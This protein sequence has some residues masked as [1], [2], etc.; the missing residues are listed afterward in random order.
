MIEE[1]KMNRVKTKRKTVK[2]DAKRYSFSFEKSLINAFIEKAGE[3]GYNT[4][5]ALEVLMQKAI[6][7][8]LPKKTVWDISGQTVLRATVGNPFTS[9]KEVKEA[10]E[11]ATT[12]RIDSKSHIKEST[13][14]EKEL[15]QLDPTSKFLMKEMQRKTHNAF[16]LLQN[17][18]VKENQL[19]SVVKGPN[20]EEIFG[21]L[22]VYVA[23][24]TGKV[25]AVDVEKQE[26]QFIIEGQ[27]SGEVNNTMSKLLFNPEWKIKINKYTTEIE[28]Q[29]KQ[30]QFKQE[31]L[32]KAGDVIETQ[33]GKIAVEAVD[34]QRTTFRF[35]K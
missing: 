4:T 28:Q 18:L 8:L 19:E 6:D 2:R 33:R 29:I 12:S 15:D 25:I 32:F 22:K 11:K 21:S 9:M 13:Q 34:D 10:V 24:N 31:Q 23:L 20:V 35:R 1:N 17:H 27:E 5:E 26:L 30:L 16:V 14:E 7:G 3:C